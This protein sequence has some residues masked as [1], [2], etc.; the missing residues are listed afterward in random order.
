MTDKPVFDLSQCPI[1]RAQPNFRSVQLRRKMMVFEYEE[2]VKTLKNIGI[3]VLVLVGVM[4]S[5]I[6]TSVLIG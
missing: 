2:D 1:I 4:F 3:N 6:V 5:L